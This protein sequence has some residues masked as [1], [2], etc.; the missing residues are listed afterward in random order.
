MLLFE[1]IQYYVKN[2]DDNVRNAVSEVSA[3][4]HGP[5]IC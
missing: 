3:V 2:G 4:S 5:Q 1:G